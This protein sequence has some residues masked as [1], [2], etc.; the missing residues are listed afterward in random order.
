LIAPRQAADRH[1]ALGLEALDVDDTD[2]TRSVSVKRSITQ[3][4]KY[5]GES[6]GDL[7][8]GE[9]KGADGKKVLVQ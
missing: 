2:G 5:L 9:A 6:C 8:A 4:G 3:T 7:K 1:R